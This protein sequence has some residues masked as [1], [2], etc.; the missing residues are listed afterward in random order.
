[1]DEEKFI[2]WRR[3]IEAAYD[4]AGRVLPAAETFA[5]PVDYTTHLTIR[6]AQEIAMSFANVHDDV[7]ALLSIEDI[8][9]GYQTFRQESKKQSQLIRELQ[10]QIERLEERLSAGG[11]GRG[12]RGQA[13]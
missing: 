5:N 1:M 2:V 7:G 11:P 12:N 8:A 4:S 6:A 10:E 9:K 13:T 3:Y